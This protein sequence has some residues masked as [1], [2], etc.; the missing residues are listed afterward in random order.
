MLKNGRA[1]FKMTIFQHHAWKDS[2]N[3][4]LH[5]FWISDDL[6]FMEE[7][8]LERAYER[9]T[10]KSFFKKLFFK[11]W[12]ICKQLLSKSRLGW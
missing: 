4:N 10:T 1:Y 3:L 12:K 11:C 8:L 2:T 6:D 9:S 5:I 7:K